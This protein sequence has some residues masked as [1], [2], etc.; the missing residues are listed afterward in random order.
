MKNKGT[1]IVELIICVVII[2]IIIF[3]SLPFLSKYSINKGKEQVEIDYKVEQYDKSSLGMNYYSNGILYQNCKI[4]KFYH[5]NED[6]INNFISGKNVVDIKITKYQ[7][8]II[9]INDLKGNK[10]EE[11]N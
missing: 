2:L 5:A 10:Y 8:F 1:T 3:V 11:I 4:K 9:Y 6:K 7:I